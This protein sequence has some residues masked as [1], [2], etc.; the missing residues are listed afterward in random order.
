MAAV[1]VYQGVLAIPYYL[2]LPKTPLIIVTLPPVRHFVM[3]IWSFNRTGE[4]IL[5]ALIIL[6]SSAEKSE[7][8]E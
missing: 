2:E 8:C 5:P 4:T 7:R 6:K 3:V 1:I